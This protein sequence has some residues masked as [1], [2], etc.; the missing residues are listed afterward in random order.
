MIASS[1]KATGK[2]VKAAIDSDRAMAFACYPPNARD[3]G[4]VVN[5]LARTHG[6]RIAPAAVQRIVRAADGDRAVMAREVEK[7]AL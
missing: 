3:A 7:L 5:D 1:V 4:A 2:L 6:L